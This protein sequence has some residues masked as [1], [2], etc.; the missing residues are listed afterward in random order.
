[1]NVVARI[2]WS[3]SSA[4]IVKIGP[5]TVSA[6]VIDWSVEEDKKKGSSSLMSIIRI[7]I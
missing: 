2:G 1:M 7:A 3:V 5:V 6:I 4:V